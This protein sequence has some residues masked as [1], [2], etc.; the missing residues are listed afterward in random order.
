[1]RRTFLIAVLVA[2]VSVPAFATTKLGEA[3]RALRHD[4]VF[5]AADADRAIEVSEAAQLR[6]LI[7]RDPLPV[8]IAILNVD[9][10]SEASSADALPQALAKQTARPG[11][12]AV[13]AGKN[14]RAAATTNIGLARG[15]AGRLA[16]QAFDEN[17]PST[18]G[19]RVL[20]M[21]AA[22]VHLVQSATHAQDAPPAYA[23]RSGGN[24]LVAPERFQQ[25][26]RSNPGSPP[27][28]IFLFVVVLIGALV[29]VFVKRGG[30]GTSMGGFRPPPIGRSTMVNG[31]T[32]FYHPGGMHGGTMYQAGYYNGA[33]MLTAGFLYG[34][35]AGREDEEPEQQRGFGSFL[36][37]SGSHDSGF[38]NS[39]GGGSWSSGDSSGGSSMGSSSTPDTPH[40]S[41]GGS[42]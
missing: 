23:P 1:M 17:H 12:Y 39:A 9:A 28:F 36:G 42:W 10:T 7:R 4:P 19:G 8:F 32:V 38:D 14:F 5:V 22:W 15:E 2:L 16:T 6:A 41:G 26:P 13:I 31:Q 30:G 21:L 18:T 11:A 35:I 40:D 29:S 37:G 34:S 25:F 3:A 20:P 24:V 27:I 33:N